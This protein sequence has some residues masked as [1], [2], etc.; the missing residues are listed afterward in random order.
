VPPPKPLPDPLPVPPP[1]PISYLSNLREQIDSTEALTFQ[2][3]SALFL[4]LKQGIQEGD[5]VDDVRS[6]LTKLRKRDDLFAKVAGE[7]DELL[8]AAPRQ[9]AMAAAAP[10]PAPPQVRTATVDPA[11][12]TPP[13]A[14]EQPMRVVPA[15]DAAAGS[16][17]DRI[18]TYQA[19]PTPRPGDKPWSTGWM[20][21]LVIGTFIFPILGI[22]AGIVGMQSPARKSQ[23][24][25]LLI[26]GI[27]MIVVN[28]FLLF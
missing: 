2:E 18:N 25:G 27:I 12:L 5:S 26:L 9:P 4:R 20:I 11:P 21:G 10:N 15:P 8:A 23:G 7:I 16:L 22:V 17:R 28:Y 14:V 19:A 1:V 13:P 6:L 24:Q 3:Q